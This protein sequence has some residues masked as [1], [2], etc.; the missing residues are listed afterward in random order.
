[1]RK[2]G[3]WYVLVEL[4]LAA[5]CMPNKASFPSVEVQRGQ[6]ERVLIQP[7]YIHFLVWSTPSHAQWGCVCVD[8]AIYKN[9]F[10]KKLPAGR[11][12]A[13]PNSC[14]LNLAKQKHLHLSAQADVPIQLEMLQHGQEQYSTNIVDGF[15]H[16]LYYSKIL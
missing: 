16:S 2:S 13:M 1:M 8:T 5:V 9:T 4:F 11:S 7:N 15:R 14:Y 10:N 12:I 3:N 6:C